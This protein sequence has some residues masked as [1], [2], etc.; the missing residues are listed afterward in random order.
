MKRAFNRTLFGG[1]LAKWKREKNVDDTAR[2][3]IAERFE[4]ETKRARVLIAEAEKRRGRHNTRK[5]STLVSRAVGRVEE[6]ITKRLATELEKNG[7]HV[8]TLI[9]DA[10]IIE[11]KDRNVDAHK[12]KAEITRI[13]HEALEQEMCERGWGAGLARA[14]VTKT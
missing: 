7:W 10:I 5:D 9:H 14:K 11:R 12:E 6:Q 1:S 8:G 13:V 3:E 4:K 2:S